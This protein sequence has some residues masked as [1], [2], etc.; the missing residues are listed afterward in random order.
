MFVCW[1]DE[2]AATGPGQINQW[3][4]W[5]TFGPPEL[6]VKTGKSKQSTG[7][8]HLLRADFHLHFCPFDL[9]D[10]TLFHQQ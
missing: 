1:A 10:V 6:Q 7:G 3:A 4:A 5:R 2:Y 8:F 9:A